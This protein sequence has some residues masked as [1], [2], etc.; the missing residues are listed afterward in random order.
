MAPAEVPAAATAA[1]TSS[2]A[3][4][5]SR[6]LGHLLLG[7]LEFYGA[8]CCHFCS[9][10]MTVFLNLIHVTGRKLDHRRV[11]IAPRLHAK[12]GS[13]GCFY[14]LTAMVSTLVINDPLDPQV[15]FFSFIVCL[16]VRVCIYAYM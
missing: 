2:S 14:Y 5:A 4:A 12:S 7:F 1:A 15:C 6:D 13:G 3:A 16:S 9:R 11:G 8:N 10:R